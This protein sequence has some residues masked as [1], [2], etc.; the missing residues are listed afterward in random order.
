MARRSVILVLLFLLPAGA[1]AQ[2]SITGVVRDTSGGVL[3]GVQVEAASPALIEKVRT[4]FTDSQGVYTI[5]DLRPGT[6]TVTFT[7]QGFTSVVRE[8]VD[9]PAAFTATVNADLRVGAV[10]ET[11]TVSGAAPVVDLRAAVPQQIVSREVRDALPLSN[12]AAAFVVVLPAATQEAVNRDVG[13][14]RGEQAQNFTI[15]GTRNNDLQILRDGMDYGQLFAGGNRSTSAN[16]AAIVE[17]VVQA[18]GTARAETGGAQLNFI[19]RDGGNLLHGTFIAN[20]GHRNLQDENLTDALRARGATA[21]SDIRTLYETAGGVGGPLRQDRLWFFGSARRWITESNLAGLYH[22]RLQ[23]TLFFEPDTARPA[24]ENNFFNDLA[25]R[26]TWQASERHK[27]SFQH[28]REDNCQCHVGMRPGTLSPEAAGD[29]HFKPSHR[30]QAKWTFPATTRLLFDAGTSLIWGKVVRRS[31]GGGPDDFVVT[32]LNRNF[33]Y[34]H[35]ARNYQQPPNTGGQIPYANRTEQFNVA[36]VTGSHSLSG[37][38]QIRQAY[39]RREHFI[40]HSMQYTFRG[41]EPQQISL[42]IS[43]FISETQ[44]RTYGIYAQEQWTLRRLTVNAGLRYDYFN[45]FIPETTVPAGRFLPLGASFPK[46]ADALNFKDINPRLGIVYDLFGTGRTAVKAS[47][48]RY[49]GIIT[50]QADILR[51]QAPALQMVTN[52]TRTWAD[53]NRD[54]VP[55]CDFLAPAA[56]GE[57]GPLSNVNFGRTIAG[58]A[59]DRGVTRG[60]GA[61]DYNWQFSL[62]GVHEVLPGFGLEVAWFRTSFGNFLVTDNRAVTAADYTEYSV[63]APSDQRLP[64]GGG[65]R[66]GPLYD[67]NPNRFG[68]VDNLVRN[69][70]AFGEQIEI[71]N[72]IEVSMNARFPNGA[73][74][75]GGFTV[76]KEVTDDCAVIRGNPQLIRSDSLTVNARNTSTLDTASLSVP[77]C[78]VD[79]PW[80]AGA[81]FRAAA[82]YPLPWDVRV[83]G[84]IQNVPGIPTSASFVYGS[85]VAQS[86]LGRP[87]SGGAN[88][89]RT[90]ELVTPQTYYTEPRGSQIDFRVSRRFDMGG[91]RVEPQFNV[92]NLTNSNDVLA[93][94]TRFGPAWQ[95]VSSV[96]PPRMI[97]L[98]VQ[99]DF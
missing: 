37:G 99:V 98:G 93:M 68:Q 61:R 35:H 70:K 48:G 51:G 9:L 67:L 50:T 71:Y 1:S 36:Y 77:I 39:Q 49:V 66:V 58:T 26:L 46:V 59:Y 17:T 8:G 45:G 91:T 20:F 89:T 15:H 44:Q 83:S 76:A 18:G 81:Q 24:F 73:V 55:Q 57:C 74:L 43:P 10:E 75:T 4:V 84:T 22:N 90:V 82:V 62:A 88:A 79:P 6:Y 16:P 47:L 33:T 64:G 95:N 11:V 53:A 3:P 2:S 97:K 96:L 52:A 63:V 27:V 80:S 60:W 94:T 42:W 40:N 56:N 7:L 21:G 28:S 19:P 12:N 29:N 14:I 32:D 38:I 54:Y 86:S 78:R 31:T 23:G 69:A 5:I 41:L 87:L 72:G 85:A 30:T 13:G 92:Y 25:L 34:G 65:Q